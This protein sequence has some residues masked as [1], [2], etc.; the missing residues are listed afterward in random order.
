MNQNAYACDAYA[1]AYA[2][3]YACDAYVGND[4]FYS[5]FLCANCCVAVVRLC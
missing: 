1:Y 4:H 5:T 2:Y 3:V